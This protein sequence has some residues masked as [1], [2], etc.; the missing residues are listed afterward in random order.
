MEHLGKGMMLVGLLIVIAGIVTW[1]FDD[2]LRF[3]GRFAG[4][5]TD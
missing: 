3:L 1:L 5:Y 4:G 2:K